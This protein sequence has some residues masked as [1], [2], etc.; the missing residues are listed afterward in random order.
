MAYKKITEV[1]SAEELKNSD[2]L[3]VI[4]DG[5]LKQLPSSKANIGG[6]K[7]KTGDVVYSTDVPKFHFGVMSWEDYVKN[8][9]NSMDTKMPIGLV[10]DPVKRTFLFCELLGKSF[11]NSDNI[12]TYFGG[13][14]SFEDGSEAFERIAKLSGTS[15][16]A[17]I[18]AFYGLRNL[19]N[20]GTIFYVKNQTAYVPALKE[21]KTA[22]EH[23]CTAFYGDDNSYAG[24]MDRLIALKTGVTLSRTLFMGYHSDNSPKL[25]YSQLSTVGKT[26]LDGNVANGAYN[27]NGEMPDWDNASSS[28]QACCPIF[29]IYT[30]EEENA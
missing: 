13:Y 17:D 19:T 2:S 15:K 25:F 14:T 8:P 21:W 18:P 1:N 5:E 26:M 11:C 30:E 22:K 28:V 9:T 20:T 27:M 3:L 23:L 29:G 16:A 6:G 4:S 10:V 7:F 12:E 24:F